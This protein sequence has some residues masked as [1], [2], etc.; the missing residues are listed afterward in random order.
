M[1][2]DVVMHIDILNVSRMTANIA[3]FVEG[4]FA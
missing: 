4:V 3:P 2:Y 1:A